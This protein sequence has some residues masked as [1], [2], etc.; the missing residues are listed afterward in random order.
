M[1]ENTKLG[2]MYKENKVK[3]VSKEEYIERVI[4]FLEYL[5][6]DILIQRIFGRAPEENTL[7]VNWNESWWKIRDEIVDE[8]V[9]G[10]Q[11]RGMKCDYLNGKA[12][13]G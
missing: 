11:D 1:V 12:I 8:M 3:M 2:I 13:K 9:K 6:E 5:H 7:F 10:T 4:T